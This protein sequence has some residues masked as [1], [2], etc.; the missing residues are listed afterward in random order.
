MLV[1]LTYFILDDLSNIATTLGMFAVASLRLAPLANLV[2]VGINQ[3]LNNR[4]VVDLYK[5]L[6]TLNNQNESPISLSKKDDSELFYSLNLQKVSFSYSDVNE[7]LDPKNI[8]L[9]IKNGNR[10][11]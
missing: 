11:V 8:S 9:S 1:S 2:V 3:I 10:L 7:K 5:D 4:A 6:N